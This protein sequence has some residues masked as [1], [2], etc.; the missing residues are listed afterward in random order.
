METDH[1][2]QLLK[3]R[4]RS[5]ISLGFYEVFDEEPFAIYVRS[6]K[7]VNHILHFL[8]SVITAGLW[9]PIWLILSLRVRKMFIIAVDESGNVTERRWR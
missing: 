1:R 8:I 3:D 9:L 6:T 7:K 2:Q 5:K 4:V